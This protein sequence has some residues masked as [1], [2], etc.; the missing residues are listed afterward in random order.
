MPR[1]V[2]HVRSEVDDINAFGF[3]YDIGRITSTRGRAGLRATF[4]N[5][6]APYVD[7]TVYREFN[8]RR[9]RRCSTG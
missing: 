9:N 7:A 5:G 6:F 1:P 2:G 4:G 3:N 8:G